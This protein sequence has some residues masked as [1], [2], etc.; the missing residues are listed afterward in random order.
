MRSCRT[1]GFLPDFARRGLLPIFACIELAF[2][3][4]ALVECITISVN[5]SELA[6]AVVAPN[7][8][9][10]GPD[11]L[12]WIVAAGH[13]AAQSIW[14]KSLP[15]M[16]A[17]WSTPRQPRI[18]GAMSCSDPPSASLP[19]YSLTKMNGTGNVVW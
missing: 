13:D 7:D 19:W 11:E 17:G 1:A 5:D 15:V 6:A 8:A 9:S 3:Q 2:R 10:G 4:G 18:V 16:A 12:S 14:R